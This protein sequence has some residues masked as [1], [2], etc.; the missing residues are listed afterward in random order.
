MNTPYQ[1]T[2][3]AEQ[4]PTVAELNF[5]EESPPGLFPENQDSNFGL[6]I[7]KLWTDRLQT[8]I[9]QL[10]TIYLER[11]VATSTQFL[12]EW[13]KEVG[14]PQN[15]GKTDAERRSRISSRLIQQPFTTARVRSVIEDYIEATF[16]ESA[17][18]TPEGLALTSG[19]IPLYSGVTS[20][21]GAYRIYWNPQTFSYEIW[22]KNGVTVDT[23]ALNRE[24]NRITPAHMSYTIDATHTNVLDYFRTIRNKQPVAY[25]RLGANFNDS[26]GYANNGAANGGVGAGSGPM[27]I[28][29]AVAAGDFATDFDGV[30]D[31]VGVPFAAQLNVGDHFT[32]M[33]WIRVDSMAANGTIFINHTGSVE[34]HFSTEGRIRITNA[35][36]G[37]Y[38]FSTNPIIVAGLT[39][40]IAYTNKFGIHRLYVNGQRV[41]LTVSGSQPPFSDI[42]TAAFLIG[43]HYTGRKF[44]GVIDEVALFNYAM[45]EAQITE[46]YN[47]GKNIQQLY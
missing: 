31:Y 47:T 17:A 24:L 18:L 16:G 25:Y 12:D 23:A 8:A 22:L 30:D 33:A 42:D 45:S 13:E 5:M 26:S 15:P 41:G 46:I 37:D 6:L 1:P 35:N 20:L 2:L 14:L 11:F 29:A 7:R 44:N 9:D 27:L 34:L 10:E 39:Y 3:P 36:V 38:E 40:F 4:P 28:D 19:G 43:T 21:L 32:A